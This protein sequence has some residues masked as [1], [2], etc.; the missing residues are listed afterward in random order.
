[1][2][3]N[4]YALCAL[5]KIYRK[6]FDLSQSDIAKDICVPSYVSKIENGEIEPN[7]Q[8][9]ELLLKKVGVNYRTENNFSEDEKNK[10]MEYFNSLF[11]FDRYHSEEIFPDIKKKK[12]KYLNSDYLI[13]YLM[14]EWHHLNSNEKNENRQTEIEYLLSSVKNL[15]PSREKGILYYLKSLSNESPE[16]KKEL[17]KNAV[18]EYKNGYYFYQLGFTML[19]GG[20]YTQSLKYLDKADEIF[21]EE[22]NFRGLVFSKSI[23]GEVYYQLKDFDNSEIHNEG[24]INLLEKSRTEDTYILGFKYFALRSLANTAHN[25]GDFKKMEKICKRII[26]DQKKLGKIYTTSPYLLLSDFYFKNGEKELAIKYLKEA[27]KVQDVTLTVDLPF[28]KELWNL[29]EYRTRHDDY[30]RTREYEKILLK[31][32]DIVENRGCFDYQG[33]VYDMLKEF[34]V[35]N[36]RYKDAFFTSEKGL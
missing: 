12:K 3:N 27:E 22:G 18:M 17:L 9:V 5:V 4:D 1:M 35:A 15:M 8:I 19:A 29:Y 23:R 34:Y 10:I 28:E 20:N 13:E 32:K 14:I 16:T 24:V 36:K 30:L 21:M 31:L 33:V 25:T 26:D 2:K 7:I 6:K 11:D